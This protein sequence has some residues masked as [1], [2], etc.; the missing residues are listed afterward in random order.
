MVTAFCYAGIR[1]KIAISLGLIA[2]TPQASLPNLSYSIAFPIA[3]VQR[4]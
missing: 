1:I 2:T 3:V 4:A